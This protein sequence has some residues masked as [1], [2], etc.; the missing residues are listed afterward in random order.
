[1]LRE[2]T[3]SVAALVSGFTKCMQGS[4]GRREG[5]KFSSAIILL[6]CILQNS[7]KNYFVKLSAF[8]QGTFFRFREIFLHSI[9]Y[10]L[11]ISFCVFVSLF[12]TLYLARNRRNTWNWV[13][14]TCDSKC[15][16]RWKNFLPFFSISLF[17]VKTC[18]L[19]MKESKHVVDSDCSTKSLK[20]CVRC[21][22]CMS[23]LLIL[24]VATHR[25]LTIKIGVCII[26]EKHFS[27]RQNFT[28]KFKLKFKIRKK[29]SRTDF[30]HSTESENPVLIV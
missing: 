21:R 25:K 4:D 26:N 12:T 9:V 11:V 24:R 17:C 16:M 15:C 6:F 14:V 29:Y 30:H 20:K 3:P 13:I 8:S 7:R 28:F 2:F 23:L 1:M 22:K 19:L 5:V 10:L 27:R 18:H